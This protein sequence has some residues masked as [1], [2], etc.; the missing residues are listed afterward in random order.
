MKRLLIVGVIG[1]AFV[2]ETVT[3]DAADKHP[4]PAHLRA[5]FERFLAETKPIP[6]NL[7]TLFSHFLMERSMTAFLDS[8]LRKGNPPETFTEAVP[9]QDVEQTIPGVRALVKLAANGP[10]EIYLSGA[11]AEKTSVLRAPVAALLRPDCVQPSAV[12]ESAGPRKQFEIGD[13]LKLSFF[14]NVPD[15]EK[16]KWGNGTDFE[17]HP[18]LSGEYVV[19][20]DGTVSVP[21]LGSFEVTELTPK[22]LQRE[23]G[24]VFNHVLGRKGFV[25]IVSVERPPIFVLGPVKTPGSYAYSQG[26]TVLH[27]VTLAGGFPRDDDAQP[28]QRLE[29]VREQTKQYGALESMTELLA[30]QTVLKAERDRGTPTAPPRL[31]ELVGPDKAVAMI[32]AEVDL[33]SGI[34]A[35]RAAQLQSAAEAVKMAQLD[36][37][38]LAAKSASFAGAMDANVKALTKHADALDDLNRRGVIANYQLIDARTRVSDAERNR[39]EIVTQLA[40]AKER[41][42]TAQ[43]SQTTLAATTRGD[44]DNQILALGQQIADA[45]RENMASKGVLGTLRVGY[46][47]PAAGMTYEIVRQTV[48]GAVALSATGMTTLIPGDL[49]RVATNSRDGGDDSKGEPATPG[50]PNTRQAAATACR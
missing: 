17:A 20:D 21:I 34:V 42:A 30:R 48:K 12:A 33:R 25:T 44:L 27:A 39:H 2:A 13:K 15:A 36:V 22:E 24:D 49:V 43:Q 7:R 40:Q 1:W 23:M 16:N 9:L 19:Q 38:Q 45:G 35:A 18:E 50:Q 41:L 37:D 5:Q 31:V 6:D 10:A 26:M 46:N 47:T 32:S 29:W 8:H 28:W 4:I 11:G 3:T 14:E